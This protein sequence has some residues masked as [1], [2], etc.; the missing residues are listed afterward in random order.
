LTT[1]LTILYLQRKSE[2]LHKNQ[3]NRE[4]KLKYNVSMREK[5]LTNS[6]TNTISLQINV[7]AEPNEKIKGREA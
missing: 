1:Y 6:C 3:I 5:V 2:Y 7:D 4:I